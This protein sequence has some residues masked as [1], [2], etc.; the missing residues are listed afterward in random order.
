ML[1]QDRCIIALLCNTANVLWLKIYINNFWFCVIIALFHIFALVSCSYTC[2]NYHAQHF[3]PYYVLAARK[4]LITNLEQKAK[5]IIKTQSRWQVLLNKAQKWH[6]NKT[7]EW[8]LQWKGKKKNN[9]SVQTDAIFSP[10][11]FFSNL[12]VKLFI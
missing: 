7:N 3:F 12:G 4:Q 5:T 6:D 11:T 2:K 1:M 8:T 9:F 10:P